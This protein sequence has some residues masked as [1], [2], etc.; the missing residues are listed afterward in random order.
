MLTVVPMLNLLPTSTLSFRTPFEILFGSFPTYDHL[1]AFG[2][3][4]YPHLSFTTQ[5]KLSPWS[6]T[7]VYLGPSY[8]HCGYRCLDLI[9]QCF[10]ISRHVIYDEDQFPLQTFMITLIMVNT[11]F[12]SKNGLT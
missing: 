12:S 1:H 11:Y 10:I 8:D 9:T 7:Y 4:C 2:C 3:L 6:S 5:H